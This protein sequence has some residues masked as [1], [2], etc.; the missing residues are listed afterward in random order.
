VRSVM[1]AL[2]SANIVNAVVN[3]LLIYGHAGFPRMGVSGAAAATVFSR[4]YMAAFLFCAIIV[5]ERRNTSGLFDVPLAIDWRRSWRLLQ[6]GGPASM[7]AVL[8]Y[9]VFAAATALAGRF[10]PAQVAAHQIALNIAAVSFMIPFGLSSAAAVRVGHAIGARE[11]TAAARSGWTAI[12]IGVTFM[13]CAALAFVTVGKY[14]IGAFTTDQSVLDVGVRLLLVAALFQLF[15]GLQGVTT[16]VLRGVGD[17]HTAMRWNLIG[18]WVVGL[19]L[20]YFLAF[21]RNWGVVGLWVGLS[22]GLIT[23]GAVL[24]AVWTRDIHRLRVSQTVR[25]SDGRAV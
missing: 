7:Q 23:V 8:E 1:F 25:Q 12:L 10:A 13:S 14:L 16:G 19:P 5:A 24:I 17:T 20:G 3:Y 21:N 2:V 6:L 18:H 22:A 11:I 9:G 4:L 15:D